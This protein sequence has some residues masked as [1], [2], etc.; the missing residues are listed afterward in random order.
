MSSS[1]YRN[2]NLATLTIIQSPFGNSISRIDLNNHHEKVEKTI[3]VK[4]LHEAIGLTLDIENQQMYFT[5]LCGAVYTAKMDGSDEKVLL[6]DVGDLTGI[7][8]CSVEQPS[9]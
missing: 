7:T 5:D 2:I 9:E 1:R 4:K 6:P 3:L 8:S